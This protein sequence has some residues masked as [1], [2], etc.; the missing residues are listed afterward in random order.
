MS[1]EN[2]GTARGIFVVVVMMMM[3][4]VVALVV[5]VLEALARVVAA[6]IRLDFVVIFGG[7]RY[8]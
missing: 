3:D 6:V 8:E 2:D 7:R 1:F 5:L 4:F